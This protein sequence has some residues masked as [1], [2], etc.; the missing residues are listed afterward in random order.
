MV[1]RIDK[2]Q[3]PDMYRV[4][5]T[6]ETKRDKPNSDQ[7]QQEGSEFQRQEKKTYEKAFQTRSIRSKTFRV[8]VD[9]IGKLIFR[10]AIPYHGSATCEADLHWKDGRVTENIAFLLKNWQDF[11]RM[12]NLKTGTEL[13]EVF[14]KTEKKILE[15]TIRQKGATSGSLNIKEM[16]KLDQNEAEHIAT[17]AQT[18][19]EAVLRLFGILD[20]KGKVNKIAY[21]LYGAGFLIVLVLLVILI[22][23]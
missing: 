8:S 19:R 6:T 15:I 21:G 12:K 3:K 10:K 16:Q 4:K 18:T 2:P 23:S 1:D 22:K 11:L 5:Q 7:Q 9:K 20:A 17:K 13:A 14:W